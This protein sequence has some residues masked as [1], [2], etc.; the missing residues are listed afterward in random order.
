MA[1]SFRSERLIYCGLEDT[2]RDKA[3]ILSILSDRTS[4]E[5]ATNYLVKPASSADVDS[6]MRGFR[7]AFLG[8]LVCIPNPSAPQTPS[9]IGYVNL[10]HTTHPHHRSCTMSIR[11]LPAAQGRG[12]GSEA[13]KWVLEWGFL[14][15]GLHRIIFVDATPQCNS[16]MQLLDLPAEL[17]LAIGGEL[18][19]QNELAAFLRVNQYLYNLLTPALYR[20][21]A[22]DQK[23]PFWAAWTGQL[24]TLQNAQSVGII[25]DIDMGKLLHLAAGNNQVSIL[26]YLL[27][28]EHNCALKWV[29]CP[30]IQG[31]CSTTPL[32]AASQSGHY[33]AVKV[34]LDHGADYTI[35]GYKGRT[36]LHLAAM[37]GYPIVVELLLDHGADVS[38]IEERQ[39]TALHYACSNGNIDVAKLLIDRGADVS[40][41]D[42]RQW[43]P[44]DFACSNGNLDIVMLLVNRGADLCAGYREGRSPIYMAVKSKN[45]ELV[46]FLLSMGCDPMSREKDGSTLLHRAARYNQHE[47]CELLI[48]HGSQVSARTNL[49]AAVLDWAAKGA[50]ARMITILLGAGAEVTSTNVKGLSALHRAAAYA[51]LDALKLLIDAGSDVNLRCFEGGGYTPLF[52]ALRK[53]RLDAMRVLLDEG[54]DVNAKL[55]KGS[56]LLHAAAGARGIPIDIVRLLVERGANTA[57]RDGRDRTPLDVALA[58]GNYGVGEFLSG[59]EPVGLHL[60]SNEEVY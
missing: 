32:A 1:S 28:V 31:D 47:M 20:R 44:L 18:H 53:C 41:F 59:N 51:P 58:V 14:V 13:I 38:A 40:T 19:S 4:S 25:S 22:V 11:I 17:L 21:D 26:E 15:A 30:Q 9:I 35:T 60:D 23:S 5:S 57:A 7:E 52:E 42:G 46:S 39:W 27:H 33:D 2:P 8:V 12:Y 10:Q 6:F 29:S 37:F 3:F 54:A 50:D 48:S 16:S 55:D 45:L 24:K 34:L 43:A 56:T 36:P 49:G